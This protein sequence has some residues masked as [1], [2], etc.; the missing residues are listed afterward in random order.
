MKTEDLID[1]L[2]NCINDITFSLN[3]VKCGITCMVDNGKPTFDMWYGENVSQYDNIHTLMNDKIF[4]GKSLS[5]IAEN[6][7]FNII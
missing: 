7:N 5:E 4:L 3:N 6:T 1:I 2:E